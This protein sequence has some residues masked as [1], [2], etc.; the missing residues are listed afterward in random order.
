VGHDKCM[1]EGMNGSNG[2]VW[3]VRG[4]GVCILLLSG[5]CAH[6]QVDG[7]SLPVGKPRTAVA[8][9]APAPQYPTSPG[10]VL[11]STRLAQKCD[12]GEPTDGAQTDFN[13][14]LLRIAGMERL[15]RIAKCMLQGPLRDVTVT[16]T[17]HSDNR[18]TGPY[19]QNLGTLRARTV[20]DY[21]VER[22]VESAHVALVPRSARSA[23][24]AGSKPRP[25]GRNVELDEATPTPH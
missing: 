21:L 10:L 19:N 4:L 12:L 13:A 8:A 5:A 23:A 25:R 15:D 9:G 1:P 16:V 20:R 6:E 22:G 2:H 18:H 17:S 3:S 7:A 11:S 24:S 14:S